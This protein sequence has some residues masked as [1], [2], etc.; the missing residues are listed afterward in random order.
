MEILLDIVCK[1][2]K[3]KDFFKPTKRR[4]KE[5]MESDAGQLMS[6]VGVMKK[7]LQ[8]TGSRVEYLPMLS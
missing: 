3:L 8:R 7:I 1:N 4:T 2:M 5:E 6:H